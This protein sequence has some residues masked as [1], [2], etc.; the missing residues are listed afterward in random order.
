MV[1]REDLIERLEQ[2]V[3]DYFCLP[4]QGFVPHWAIKYWRLHQAVAEYLDHD[5]FV[6]PEEFVYKMD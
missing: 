5:T 4:H 1:S 6:P 2:D 3:E